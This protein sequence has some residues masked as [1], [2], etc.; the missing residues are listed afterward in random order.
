MP[1]SSLQGGGRG[2]RGTLHRQLRC[3]RPPAPLTR[4]RGPH[5]RLNV[6][7]PNTQC[8]L[9]AA[10]EHALSADHDAITAGPGPVTGVV[11]GLRLSPQPSLSHSKPCPPSSTITATLPPDA[12][13]AFSALALL[14]F[15]LQRP[16]ST[17]QPKG[18][19]QMDSPER[20]CRDADEL[21]LRPQPRAAA[22]GTQRG[23]SFLVPPLSSAG[24]A[25]ALPSRG[26]LASL[27]HQLGGSK[28][29]KLSSRMVFFFF[30]G[31]FSSEQF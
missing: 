16:L 17:Q 25:R 7:Q 3:A 11:L 18:C 9:R 29:G 4:V 22:P 24:K 20:H 21:P 31:R 12:V 13:T 2:R 8:L 30:N 10:W 23:R 15:A 14:S 19:R 27:A 28:N 26:Q 6:P 1:L 5:L